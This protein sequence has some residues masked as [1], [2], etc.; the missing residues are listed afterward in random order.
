MVAKRDL[1]RLLLEAIREFNAQTEKDQHLSLQPEERLFGEGGLLDSLGLVNLIT[2]IEEHIE[3]KYD[4]SM[5]LAGE[6]AL[7]RR[8]S[9]FLTIGSLMAYIDELMAE[10]SDG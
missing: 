6:K 10:H 8:T 5:R 7:S 2:L 3:D 1:S 4:I 9:P